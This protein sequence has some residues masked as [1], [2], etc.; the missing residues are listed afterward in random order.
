MSEGENRCDQR[1]KLEATLQLEQQ[2]LSAKNEQLT[3]EISFLKAELEAL[4]SSSNVKQQ[5]AEGVKHQQDT[6]APILWKGCARMP[7]GTV[8]PHVIVK[9]TNVYVGGGNTG[10]LASTRTVYK[11][12]STVNSWSNLPITPYYTFALALVKGYVTVIGGM[13]V[14]LSLAS[15]SLYSFDEEETKKWCQKFPTMPTKRCASSAT[16]SESY[17]IVVGGI[18]ENDRQ[19]LNVVEVLDLSTMTWM[20]ADP[21][22]K[23]VTFMSITACSVTNRIYLLGGLTQRGAIKSV[24]SCYIPDLITSCQGKTETS[25]WEVITDAPFVRSGGAAINGKLVTASGLDSTDMT[26]STMH[27]FDPNTKKWKALG[28][29]AAARS[30]CSL[31]VLSETRVLVIGGYVDPRNWMSSLTH[32]IVEAVNLQVPRQEIED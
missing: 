17:L 1:E 2:S 6:M 21:V 15:N 29:M 28:E 13:N 23:P 18:A 30:S 3:T 25:A 27:A 5:E 14:I 19:Y 11:Y 12:D 8:R 4:R 9:E 26:T 20:K 22:P 16:S 32:D 31:A 10:K 24:F 7:C